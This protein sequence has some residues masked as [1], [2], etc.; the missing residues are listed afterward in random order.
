MSSG[1]HFSDR[2]PAILIS[3]PLPPLFRFFSSAYLN[4]SIMVF[5]GVLFFRFFCINT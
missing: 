2:K 3:A 5:V 1:L 4:C